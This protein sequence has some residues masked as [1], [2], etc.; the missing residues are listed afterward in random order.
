MAKGNVTINFVRG[1]K[2][3][4]LNSAETIALVD[5]KAEAIRSKAAGMY[6]ARSYGRKTARRGR[7]SAHAVVYTMSRFAKYENARKN[8]LSKAMRSVK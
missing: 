2:H 6:A 7:G 4:I 1:Y 3:V 8:T 5:Q